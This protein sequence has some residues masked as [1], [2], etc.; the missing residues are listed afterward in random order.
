MNY[1]QFLTL[2][3]QKLD[4]KLDQKLDKRF[5]DFEKKLDKRFEQIDQRFEKIDQRFEKI[6]KDIKEI[7]DYINVESKGIENE[8]GEIIKNHYRKTRRGDVEFVEVPIKKLHNYSDGNIITDFD[9]ALIAFVKDEFYQL[10]IIEA[11]HYVKFEKINRKLEQLYKLKHLFE[12]VTTTNITNYHKL[13]L[14]DI[15]SLKNV[16]D[17]NKLDSKILFYIGGPTWEQNADK[18]INDINSSEFDKLQFKDIFKKIKL[19]EEELKKL[20]EYVKGNIGCIIPKGT[21]YSIFDN[22]LTYEQYGGKYR[23]RFINYVE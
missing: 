22:S 12:L 11:K 16:I 2:L 17:F 15:E 4:E 10:I 1:E 5:N 20:L 23:G 9:Y 8:I 6:E 19:N 21:R 14:K 3:D 13:F 7:K 18:Y